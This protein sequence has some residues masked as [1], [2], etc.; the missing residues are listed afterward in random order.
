MGCDTVEI[1]KLFGNN[2]DQAKINPFEIQMTFDS[3]LCY[4]GKTEIE[5]PI[6]QMILIIDSQLP[7]GT[8]DSNIL[9]IFLQKSRNRRCLVCLQILAT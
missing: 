7:S 3:L 5:L 6:K 2:Y 4:I 9:G 1:E 8:Y